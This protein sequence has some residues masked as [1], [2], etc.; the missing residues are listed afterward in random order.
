M[1]TYVQSNGVR[2]TCR[3]M[4]VPTLKPGFWWWRTGFRTFHEVKQ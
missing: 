2:T 3:F 4:L 1:N